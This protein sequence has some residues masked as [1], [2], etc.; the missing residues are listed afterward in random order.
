VK[1]VLLLAA[2]PTPAPPPCEAIAKLIS[3]AAFAKRPARPWRG[4]MRAPDVRAGEA[5]RFR[6][7]LRDGAAGPPDLAGRWRVVPIGCGAGA[8]CPAFIDRRSGRVVF[9][10]DLKVVAELTPSR[11][12]TGWPRLVHR[13]DSRLL[14]AIGSANEDPARAGVSLFDWREGRP[15]LLRFVPE[16]R[17]C[18][19]P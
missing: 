18:P 9:P 14:V 1:A 19:A 15:R 2:L 17:L 7:A 11:F 6:T 16:S 10:A 5:R 12:G 13:R 3:P 4:V 8:T